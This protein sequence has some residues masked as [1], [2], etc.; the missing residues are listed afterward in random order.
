MANA[1]VLE[2]YRKKK[3]LTVKELTDKMDKTPGWYSKIKCGH[4]VLPSY[5]LPKMASILGVKPE[6]LAKEYFS[7]YELEESSSC[8]NDQ[9]PA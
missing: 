8:E 3:K 1:N 9:Q 4:F 2:K 7:E 5:H 6:V